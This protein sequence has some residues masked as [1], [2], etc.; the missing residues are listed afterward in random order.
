MTAVKEVLIDTPEGKARHPLTNPMTPTPRVAVGELRQIPLGE[1]VESPWNPRKH[2]DPAKLAEMV[3]SLKKGQLAPI[4]VRPAQWPLVGK[5]VG[6]PGTPRKYE[7]GAGHRRFRSAPGAGLTSLLAIVRDM[8][9]VAFLELLTI[10]NKQR[11]D[12][13]P[14]DEANGFR[15][16]MEKAGYDV[17]KLSARIGLSTKYVYDRLK[18]LQL[19][20]E[21]KKLLEDGAITAGHAILLARLTPSDQQRV[22]GK[23]SRNRY[24]GNS[25]GLFE[26]EDAEGEPDQGRL[27]LDEKVKARSVREL[28]TYINDHVRMPPDQVDPFLFPE[29]AAVLQ[30]A[31]EEELKIVHIS[32]D[33][34]LRVEARDSKKR[35]YSAVSW[36]RADGK[37]G[38]KT[39]DHS[40][41]GVV[42]A[43][44]G[45]GQALRVCVNRDKCKTHFGAD[46]ARAKR[47]RTMYG[48][49]SNDGGNAIQENLRRKREADRANEEKA[50]W[51]KASPAL[52]QALAAVIKKAPTGV[53]SQIGQLFLESDAMPYNHRD[54]DKYVGA[55]RTGDDLLRHFAFAHLADQCIPGNYFFNA[56]RAVKT[57]KDFGID[58]TKILNQVAPKP[59]AEK[60]PAPKTAKKG[61]R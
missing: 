47:H 54:T 28:A 58:A 35:T 49:G 44:P 19:T 60:K 36:K 8:D 6:D 40:C 22:I 2:Y 42:V 59:K 12:V 18:L 4:I 23:A 53:S 31:A 7:I 41:I 56:D 29:T 27:K 14:L 9:D 16:L 25:G 33:S 1:L 48:L 3:E 37:K 5:A 21:A 50:R 46:K 38:S 32:Y 26:F 34:S 55:G 11:D 52:C 10:E 15:L 30:A 43:G 24:A 13:T 51:T 20:P 61:G 17:A 39:C 57:L 45:R